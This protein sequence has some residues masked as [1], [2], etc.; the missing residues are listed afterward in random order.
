MSPFI[1]GA[2]IFLIEAQRFIH[3]DVIIDRR[4]GGCTIKFT[5][6]RRCYTSTQ[7]QTLC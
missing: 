2:T 3:K 7:K 6:Y 1:I 4:N 5:N